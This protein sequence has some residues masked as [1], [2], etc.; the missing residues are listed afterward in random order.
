MLSVDYLFYAISSAIDEQVSRIQRYINKRDK[1]NKNE[2]FKRS[3]IFLMQL[4]FQFLSIAYRMCMLGNRLLSDENSGNCTKEEGSPLWNLYCKYQDELVEGI[5]AI[6]A[7][8]TNRVVKC[9]PYFESHNTSRVQ[10]IKGLASGVFLGIDHY[11]DTFLK[12]LKT[13]LLQWI[14]EN[15]GAWHL[16]EGQIV[17]RTM[18]PVD[19]E[20]LDQ[21]PYNQVVGDLT[22][23]F[24]ILVGIY[25]PSVTG[26]A[27]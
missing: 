20:L 11:L 21:P 27:H 22:T 17:A 10:G 2:V 23:T 25:F 18:N 5:G 6:G 16:T 24:T 4:N 14:I 8:I 7:N 15:L 9:D 3:T 26:M 19:V 13:F 12:F 1:E